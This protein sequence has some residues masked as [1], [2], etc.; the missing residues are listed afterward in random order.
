MDHRQAAKSMDI[1]Y[2]HYRGWVT[3]ADINSRKPRIVWSGNKRSVCETI[4]EP[5]VLLTMYSKIFVINLRASKMMHS[6][7]TYF[8]KSLRK[9]QRKVT[10][11]TSCIIRRAKAWVDICS[12][13]LKMNRW[14]Y[15]G[16]YQLRKATTPRETHGLQWLHTK[17]LRRLT[18]LSM[19]TA[20]R[21]SIY[22]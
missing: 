15:T 9:W 10:E 11:H 8:T 4:R 2:R 16:L 14:R 12:R 20:I 7:S 22:M 21:C 1:N 19:T 17:W 5:L 3:E 6:I 18:L 13:C